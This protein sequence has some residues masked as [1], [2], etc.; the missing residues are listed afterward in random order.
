[1]PTPRAEDPEARLRQQNRY[2]G[3]A[4][5]ESEARH[6][7]Y[8]HVRGHV[9]AGWDALPEGLTPRNLRDLAVMAKARGDRLIHSLCREV[10]LTG[11]AESRRAG[12]EAKPPG[13]R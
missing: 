7:L 9:R 13:P 4:R 3:A 6:Q 8:L 11:P 5:V 1:M 10:D 12:L 2:G